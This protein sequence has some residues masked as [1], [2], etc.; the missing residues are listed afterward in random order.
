[1]LSLLLFVLVS[2]ANPKVAFAISVPS[3]APTWRRNDRLL[4]H[5]GKS[6]RRAREAGFALP[7]LPTALHRIVR[8][9]HQIGGDAHE[10]TG[11]PAPA[12]V[13]MIH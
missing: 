11:G 7:A 6:R 13:R 5:L 12:E 8:Y 10:T 1:M 3:A 9:A 4:K 2:T